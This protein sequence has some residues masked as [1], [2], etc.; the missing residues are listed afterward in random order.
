MHIRC[1]C[2]S[3]SSRLLLLMLLSPFLATFRTERM[4]KHKRISTRKCMNEIE[5][6]PFIREDTFRD[7]YDFE[8]IVNKNTNCFTFLLL[9]R[10]R[11]CRLR[12]S[13]EASLT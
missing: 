11:R 9:L 7:V 6:G 3:S 5:M 8:C 12:I 13:L 4:H 2:S 10:Y 1:K